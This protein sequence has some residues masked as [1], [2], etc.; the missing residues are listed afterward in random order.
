VLDSE[1]QE[2]SSIG[3]LLRANT[4]LTRMMTTFTR[5][6]FLACFRATLQLHCDTLTINTLYGSLSMDV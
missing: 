3:S 1:F 2:A 5:H 4:A 6:A